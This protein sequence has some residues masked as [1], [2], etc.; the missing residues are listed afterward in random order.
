[1]RYTILLHG[2][3]I[4]YAVG[5]RQC[6]LRVG[7]KPQ[8]T[9]D[10]IWAKHHERLKEVDP[11]TNFDEIRHLTTQVDARDAMRRGGTEVK[12]L[13]D[14]PNKDQAPGPETSFRMT[15]GER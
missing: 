10:H 5:D 3:S 11:N 13:S 8:P 12:R 15:R 4:G 6:C 14:Y 1:M 7:G 2:G 9:P